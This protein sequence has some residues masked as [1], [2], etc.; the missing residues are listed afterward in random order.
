V[1]ENAFAQMSA[2]RNGPLIEDAKKSPASAKIDREK[3][4]NAGTA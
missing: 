2:G 4:S 3:D 1:R